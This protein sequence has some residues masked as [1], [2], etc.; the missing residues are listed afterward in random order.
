MILCMAG[1]L[2]RGRPGRAVSYRNSRADPPDGRSGLA[3]G[4]PKA[5]GHA[6]ELGL[7]EAR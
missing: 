2:R 4:L 3:K 5:V 7:S 1:A 6:R